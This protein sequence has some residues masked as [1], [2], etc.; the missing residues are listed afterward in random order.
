MKLITDSLTQQLLANGRE[1]R[2]ALDNHQP[3]L[4]FKPVVKLFNILRLTGLFEHPA[5]ARH[6]RLRCVT[7]SLLTDYRPLPLP[8]G[9]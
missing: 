6:R 4:D 1:Q 7:L 3:A 2:S 5:L 8:C 9:K